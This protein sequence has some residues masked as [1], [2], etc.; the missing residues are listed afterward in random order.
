[1]NEPRIPNSECIRTEE[2]KFIRYPIHPEYVELYNLKNDPW[3]EHNL[4]EKPEYK[5]L[6]LKFNKQCDQ[7]I[8]QL[9]NSRVEK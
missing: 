4:A 9:I 3:E 1:M 6:I 2:W 5:K 7:K 8:I